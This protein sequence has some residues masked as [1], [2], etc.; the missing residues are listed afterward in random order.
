VVALGPWSMDL[1]E[2]LGYRLPLATKRGYH[3]HYKAK[4]NAGLTLPILD[5][6]GGFVITPMERG[7]RLTTGAEFARRDAPKTPVQLAKTEKLA[8]GLFP[9]AE[10]VDPEPWM[11]ARPIFPDSRPVIGAAGR[12]KGLWLAF[13]HQHLGFTMG[14]AT[15]RLLAEMIT[16]EKPYVDPAPFSPARFQ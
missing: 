15:G 13:G 4:G 8:R 12:H 6:E 5:E 10:R 7:I 16:G 9:L 14:P 11:G 1:L 2:P 3:M